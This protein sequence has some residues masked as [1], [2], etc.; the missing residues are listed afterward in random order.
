MRRKHR[1]IDKWFDRLTGKPP[2]P[3]T[4]IEGGSSIF[5]PTDGELTDSILEQDLLVNYRQL[6]LRTRRK[7][8]NY[9]QQLADGAA[10]CDN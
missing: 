9:V 6:N 10:I 4:S 7:L 8:A 5:V 3:K 1:W 2:C